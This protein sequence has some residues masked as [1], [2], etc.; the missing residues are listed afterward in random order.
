MKRLVRRL[1]V[2]LLVV[3]AL[4]CAGYGYYRYTYPYGR[5]HCCD[6]NLYQELAQYAAEHDGW[7]PRGEA[8][9]EASL[10][11][12]YRQNPFNA[13]NLRGKTVPE[14]VVLDRLR[15]GELLTPETCG[16]NYVE[17]LRADDDPRLALLWEKAGLSHFG[18]RLSDGGHVVILVSGQWQYVPGSEWPAFLEEQRR[19]LADRTEGK[20]VRADA[21][22]EFHGKPIQVQLRV[23]GGALQARRWQEGYACGMEVLANVQ[24]EPRVL[25]NVPV[26]TPT[27]I[28]NAR[29]VV[30]QEK[31][32]VRFVLNA[33]QVVFDGTKFAFQAGQQEP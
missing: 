32:R 13:Y 24:G 26:V 14:S 22:L 33:R 21:R 20:E 30:E 18:A 16:W 28:R 17:G 29:V 9:P 7:F 31:G 11:L 5:S 8:S 23:V 25:G 27:E 1:A 10:S 2:I 19:L 12:L 6:K 4:A 3:G 15:R